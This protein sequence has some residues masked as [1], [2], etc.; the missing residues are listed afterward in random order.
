M[1]QRAEMEAERLVLRQ[2]EH[3]VERKKQLAELAV[4]R[5]AALKAREAVEAQRLLLKE[6]HAKLLQQHTDI[7]VA[8]AA[9]H[10]KGG[11][12]MEMDTS[13]EEEEEDVVEVSVDDAASEKTDEDY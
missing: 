10:H 1:T 6:Q 4:H 2:R 3:E 8:E 7:H 5:A 9:A 12:E 13:S 11:Q